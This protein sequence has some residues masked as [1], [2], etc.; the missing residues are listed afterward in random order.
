MLRKISIKTRIMILVALSVITSVLIASSILFFLNNML[1]DSI[2][3]VEDVYI[4]GQ[5]EKIKT[6]T[7]NLA[8]SLSSSVK[9]L[10]REEAIAKI[11]EQTRDI[12]FENDKSGY[13]FA[14][15]NTTALSVPVKTSNENKDLGN[16]QDEKGLYFVRELNNVSENGGFVTWYFPKNANDPKA[17][18]KLGYAKKI[19]GT[20]FWIG[21][22][23][24]IDNVEQEKAKLQ[25][26]FNKFKEIVVYS[27]LL[28]GSLSVIIILGLGWGITNSINVPLQNTV[29]IAKKIANGNDNISFETDKNDELGEMQKALALMFERLT[30]NNQDLQLKNIE[31]EKKTEEIQEIV[32]KSEQ[33][34]EEALH[35]N[36]ALLK[37]SE[38]LKSVIS[39]LRDIGLSLSTQ[40]EQ[41]A[42]GASMQSDHLEH[43]LNN[44]D[45]SLSTLLETSKSADEASQICDHA[46]VTAAQSSEVVEQMSDGVKKVNERVS[47]LLI[48][49]EELEN[50]ATGIGAVI[51]VINDIADQTNLLALN[52]AIEAAR[53]GE[54]GRGFAVVADEVRKLAEKTMSSTKEV[55]NAIVSMQKSAQDNKE[56]VNLA[57]S[58]VLSV[59][60]NVTNSKN[61]LD[62]IVSLVEQSAEQVSV[63][64][65]AISDNLRSNEA[66]VESIKEV[67]TIAGQT[68]KAMLSSDET[69]R[70]LNHQAEKLELLVL[71]PG[72]SDNR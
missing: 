19:Q 62:Q 33:A 55:E 2:S 32:K 63:I 7:D 37:T 36:E 25:E 51:N 8:T 50:K 47:K 43:S 49:M 30:K 6:T 38:N 15:E 64:A 1:E 72:S 41:A 52:A 27:S 20:N 69:L 46:K 42:S 59:S 3:H 23:I 14:Y 11:K 66:T 16:V 65:K 10:P 18:P 71:V 24:Y 39:I 21:T 34:R 67:S 57:V 5:K 53:A 58:D 12:R 61:S 31:A 35:K 40:I 29:L 13:F 22:G 56:S 54:A 9:N 17:Y 68:K 45:H 44:M 60:Q 28:V 70:N 4:A 48:S 26:K